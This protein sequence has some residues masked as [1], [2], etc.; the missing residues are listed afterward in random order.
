MRI[1]KTPPEEIED[2]KYGGFYVTRKILER[3]KEND[4][5]ED[6]LNEVMPG[7]DFDKEQAMAYVYMAHNH[8]IWKEEQ[9]DL[10][11]ICQN[12]FDVLKDIDLIGTTVA[13]LPLTTFYAA[14]PHGDHGFYYSLRKDQDT[15]N[16]SMFYANTDGKHIAGLPGFTF[17]QKNFCDPHES[18]NLSKDPTNG[19]WQFQELC[20]LISL[21]IGSGNPDLRDFRNE[22]KYRSSTSQTPVKKDKSL[23]Q[24]NII[25]VGFDWKKH[26]DKS[27]YSQPYM[28]RRGKNKKLTFNKGSIKKR[29]KIQGQDV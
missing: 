4:C 23:S 10:Y 25:L 15:Y 11:Y 29:K 7:F 27:W 13:D 1:K 28:A 24:S 9:G 21:Y 12:F 19:E 8:R 6:I 16:L 22:I 14:L 3:L 20:I 5:L 26:E 17:C 18:L 2:L